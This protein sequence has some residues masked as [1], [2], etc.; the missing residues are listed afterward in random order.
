MERNNFDLE[1][2]VSHVS[3]IQN[4]S[5]IQRCSRNRLAHQV[6]R[7]E[8]PIEANEQL[9]GN[10]SRTYGT[11]REI[12]EKGWRPLWR[13]RVVGRGH[14]EVIAPTISVQQQKFFYGKK[15]FNWIRQDMKYYYKQQRNI[16]FHHSV[17]SKDEIWSN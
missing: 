7:T 4:N 14:F 10:C 9:V 15:Q 12:L 11:K 2:A 16:I 5:L 6:K 8:W 1:T 17:L 3:I 13:E